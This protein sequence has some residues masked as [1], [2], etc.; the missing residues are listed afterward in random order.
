MMLS[1]IFWLAFFHL[2][3]FA[4]FL[5][6]SMVSKDDADASKVLMALPVFVAIISLWARLLLDHRSKR[7][8]T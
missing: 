4:F 7:S 2:G 8:S 3:L 5:V 1:A 6:V